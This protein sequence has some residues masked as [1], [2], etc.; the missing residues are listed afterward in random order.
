MAFRLQHR[1]GQLKEGET[2]FNQLSNYVY[3]RAMILF[4][5]VF[6][7]YHAEAQRDK[8]H[9]VFPEPRQVE[10]IS[11]SKIHLGVLVGMNN[12]EG[13]GYN[14]SPNFAID[15]GFQPYIPFGVGAELNY[16]KSGAREETKDIERVTTLVKGM[17]NFGGDIEFINK[18]YLGAG[19]G[20]VSTDGK[21]DFVGT[22]LAGFD[23]PLSFNTA[24]MISAGAQL[25]YLIISGDQPD[26]LIGSVAFKYWF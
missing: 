13:S 1:V 10:D 8:N 22:P 17:Y 23:M 7:S 3:V 26:A 15:S 4:L 16:T 21:Y 14:T 25:K 20:I 9:T 6:L 18:S 24:Q 11:Q 19:I 2:M 5:T 12:I